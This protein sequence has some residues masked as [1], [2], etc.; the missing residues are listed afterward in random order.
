MNA[1]DYFGTTTRTMIKKGVFYKR[2]LGLSDWRWTQIACACLMLSELGISPRL[3]KID[4][5]R[6]TLVFEEII[7]FEPGMDEIPKG[8][9]ISIK[10]AK[11]QITILVE[12]MHNVGFVHGDLHLGNIGVVDGNRI[13]F[14]DFD[15]VMRLGRDDEEDWV[16]AYLKG[17]Y[18]DITTVNE[19][20]EYEETS[21]MEDGIWRQ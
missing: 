5:K 19:L 17:G 9:E 3:L 12:R 10:E 14:V 4:N 11:E 1:L 2:Y 15:S 16:K 7:P 6:K 13:V 21:W 20:M 18:D 8:V